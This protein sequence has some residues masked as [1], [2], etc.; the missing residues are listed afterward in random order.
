M[1]RHHYSKHLWR[2]DESDKRAGSSQTYYLLTMAGGCQ[3]DYNSWHIRKIVAIQTLHWTAR[4]LWNVCN[5]EIHFNILSEINLNESDGVN[6]LGALWD[7]SPWVV[8]MCSDSGR[9]QHIEIVGYDIFNTV[10]VLSGFFEILIRRWYM[11]WM[12]RDGSQ[13]FLVLALLL[14]YCS[15]R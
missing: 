15:R 7:S 11:M 8:V 2:S 5:C 10:Y 14:H 9:I 3:A 4:K 6:L 13:K 1:F 12:R